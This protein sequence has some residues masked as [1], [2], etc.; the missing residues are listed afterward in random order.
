MTL[1]GAWPLYEKKKT[2]LSYVGYSDT[3]SGGSYMSC[4]HTILYVS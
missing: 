1:D 4:Q 2:D 3:I